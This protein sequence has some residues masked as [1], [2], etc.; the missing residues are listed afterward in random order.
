MARAEP[1]EEGARVKENDR[2]I[3]WY[4]SSVGNGKMTFEQLG[5]MWVL[6]YSQGW[7]LTSSLLP[8]RKAEECA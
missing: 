2:G 8:D 3:Q 7:A 5:Q 6:S 1:P 4:P